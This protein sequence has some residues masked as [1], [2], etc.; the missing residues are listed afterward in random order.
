MSKNRETAQ[1]ILEAAM[2]LWSEKG[3]AQTTM[4]ELAKRLG[5]GS[6]SLYFYFRSKEEIVQYLYMVLDEQVLGNFRETDQGETELGTNL[7]RLLQIKLAILAPHR[8][9]LGA[10]LREAVDPESSMNPFSSDSAQV[11][12]HNINFFAMLVER[13]G[14]IKKDQIDTFAR[15]FWLLHVCVILYWLYDK[16]ANFSNTWK[17]VDKIVD[18]TM[19]LPMLSQFPGAADL[20]A[21]IS[22]ILKPPTKP[23]EQAKVAAIEISEPLKE[24]DVTVIGGGPIGVIYASFLKLQR[25]RTRILV[26]ERAAEPGHKIGESTLS[27]F[28]KALR[29]IGIRQEALRQLFYPKNGLGFHYIDESVHNITQAPEYILETFNETFQVERRVLDSLLITNA[30]RL[31]I[32]VLQGTNVLMQQCSLSSEGNIIVYQIGPRCYRIKSSLVVDASGPAGLLSRHLGLHTS[33][34]VSFQTGSVWTYYSNVRSLNNYSG[35]PNKAQFSRDHYTQHLC[36]REGWLWYIPLV[37]WQA[38]PTANLARA[39][40]RVLTSGRTIPTRQR[41]VEDYGC[42]TMDIVSIGIALRSDRDRYLADD[43][44]A[45]FQNYLHKYPAI[46]QIL[47]G[48][49]QLEDHYGTGQPFM[50]R[51]NIRSHSRQVAGDGWLLVGDA[52]FFVDPLISPGLTGGTAT[53]YMAVLETVRALDAGIFTGEFLSSYETFVHRLHDALERDNQL[54]YMSFNHPKA[55]ALVQRFQEIDA[56][57]HFLQHESQDYSIDETNVWG[58]LNPTYQELQ[59]AAW[60]IMREEEMLIGSELS[61]EEQS[62]RDYERMVERLKRLLGDYVISHSDLTPFITGNKMEVVL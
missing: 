7:K 29:S 52:A 43:P 1:K 30:R 53:A 8:S 5:M 6:S 24:Y 14:L 16:S 19:L 35:W 20:L 44:R 62:P 58:I 34:G 32:E 4:R 46:R 45:A 57:R 50:S 22:E 13:S 31:G 10:L 9:S 12:T 11:L 36:F 37:S 55:L 26:L 21:L 42:P 23:T 18:L 61:I 38:S 48:A 47:E 27:G 2:A 41:L 40:E 33:E 17:L 3:F 54:V 15:L 56:R 59:K 28:C 39:L 49:I 60:A 51:N 25:P